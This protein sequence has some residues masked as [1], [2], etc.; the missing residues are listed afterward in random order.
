MPFLIS[1]LGEYNMRLGVLKELRP[2]L[3]AT[4]S[5][6]PGSCEG[7]KNFYLL[8]GL[9][10]YMNTFKILLSSAYLFYWNHLGCKMIEIRLISRVLS[11][12][13]PSV[14]KSI[15]AYYYIRLYHIISFRLNLF[16]SVLLCFALLFLNW[17]LYHFYL[18]L[19]FYFFGNC[20]NLFSKRT[21]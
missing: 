21:S 9:I 3:V 13:K 10:S 7:K 17:F 1:C 11:I 6:K 16:C 5:E 2:K 18:A 4:F 12:W 15:G 14:S 8:F 20:S 19:I